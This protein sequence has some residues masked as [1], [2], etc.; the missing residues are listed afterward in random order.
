MSE[1][2]YEI[3]FQ[4]GEGAVREIKITE[5]GDVDWAV[6]R[7]TK[8]TRIGRL[9]DDA[10]KAGV[11]VRHVEDLE[12]LDWVDDED[13]EERVAERVSWNARRAQVAA[14][15]A[16]YDFVGNAVIAEHQREHKRE[17]KRRLE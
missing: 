7:T 16:M 13:L 8:D 3:T 14:I 6:F 11:Q 4:R 1:S 12:F 17:H 15:D 9:I 10:L 5:L 2:R